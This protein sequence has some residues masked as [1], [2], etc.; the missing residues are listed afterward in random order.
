MRAKPCSQSPSCDGFSLVEVAIALG[1]F[2]FALVALLALLPVVMQTSRDSLDRAVSTQ[3]AT[4]VAGDYE[5]RPFHTLGNNGRYYFTERGE[6]ADSPADALFY[7]VA[8]VGG[9]ESQ[10]LRRLTVEVRRGAEDATASH[11]LSFLLFDND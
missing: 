6:R 10:K 1:I 7:A 5:R 2:S 3:I 9:S 8:T 4:A 11:T